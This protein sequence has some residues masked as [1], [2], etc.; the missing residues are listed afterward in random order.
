MEESRARIVVEGN[1]INL[2]VA[3]AIPLGFVASELITNAA[4]Y[5][6][7]LI[8]IRLEPDPRY[9]YALSVCNDGPALP[10]GFDPDAGKGLGMRIVRS[11][12]RQ[13]GGELRFGRGGHGQGARFTVLFS[14]MSEKGGGRYEARCGDGRQ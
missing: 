14:L 5:G 10:E 2:S 9:G 1:E 12:V 4:K 13:I 3:T 11:F 7:G 6:K 8:T